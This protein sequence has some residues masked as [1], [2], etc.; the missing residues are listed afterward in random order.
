MKELTAFL[1]GGQLSVSRLLLQHYQALKMSSEELVVYLQL[2]DFASQNDDFPDLAVIGDRMGIAPKQIY[3]LIH[4]LLQKKLITLKSTVNDTGQ[5]EDHYDLTPA[6]TKLSILAVQDTQLNQQSMD[7]H[8]RSTVFNLVEQALGRP[9]SPLESEIVANW[10][11][12]DHYQ[13]ELIQLAVREAILN[14]V[15]SLKYVD[16]ILLNWQKQ[17][18]T[19]KTSLQ[20]YQKN[21]PRR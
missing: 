15:Y 1:Q 9:L 21:H 18:I 20:A 10:L 4:Q 19:D 7:S 2:S 3:N 8:Q 6:L 16:K 17:D 13:P 14:Q 12:L 11:D 5:A